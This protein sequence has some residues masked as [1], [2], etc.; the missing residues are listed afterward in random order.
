MREQA[1]P[2]QLECTLLRSVCTVLAMKSGERGEIL[3]ESTRKESASPSTKVC[4]SRQGC[5]QDQGSFGKKN[6]SNPEVTPNKI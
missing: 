5:A 4:E 1:A 2:Q 6:G 3:R